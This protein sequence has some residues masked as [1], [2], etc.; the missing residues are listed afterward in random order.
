MSP[1]AWPFFLL[2]I[3]P[4]RCGPSSYGSIQ[5]DKYDVEK[6]N[7]EN[8]PSPEA[9]RRNNLVGTVCTVIML[10]ATAFT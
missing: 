10:L 4:G 1:T 2:I 3:R 7:R 5:H 6:Y 9:K 8:N